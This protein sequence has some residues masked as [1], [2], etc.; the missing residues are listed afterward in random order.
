MHHWASNIDY[1]YS[2]RGQQSLDTVKSQHSFFVTR[3]K[4]VTS[5]AFPSPTKYFRPLDQP[6]RASECVR[7]G[8]CVSC[9]TRGRADHWGARFTQWYTHRGKSGARQ[10]RKMVQGTVQ[11]FRSMGK[12]ISSQTVWELFIIKTVG[13]TVRNM[14]DLPQLRELGKTPPAVCPCCV[15]A[16]VMLPVAR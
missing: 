13:K 8:R 11:K 5:H 7:R 14:S 3:F 12:V 4:C 2:L 6:F 10:V 16:F 1:L 9:W 15:Q